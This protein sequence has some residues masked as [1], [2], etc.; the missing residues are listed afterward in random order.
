M[1]CGS[2]F[3]LTSSCGIEYIYI[4]IYIYIVSENYWT[5]NF[6][7]FLLSLSLSLT[8]T[9]IIISKNKI[10]F[11][12]SKNFFPNLPS[13]FFIYWKQISANRKIKTLPNITWYFCWFRSN[14]S[15]SIREQF[16]CDLFIRVKSA[17]SFES[18]SGLDD[19]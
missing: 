3:V 13:A 6:Q 8:H 7:F 1:V 12:F 9:Q 4:Y 2:G 10:Y 15:F 18:C 19:F 11:L 14:L 16:V 17:L 5:I